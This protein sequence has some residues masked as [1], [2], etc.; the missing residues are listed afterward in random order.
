MPEW[1]ECVF[2]FLLAILPGG[3]WMAFWFF[4]VNW[5]RAWGVLAM[6]AWIPV[7]LGVFITALVW[8]SIEPGSN[9]GLPN[10]WWQLASMSALTAVALFAGWLQTISGYEPSEVPI[11]VP[12]EDHGHDHH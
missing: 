7:V 6:G 3:L 1:L 9:W 8:S 10:F 2:C 5:K 12:E 11:E 4:A